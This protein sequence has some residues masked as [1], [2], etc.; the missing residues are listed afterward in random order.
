MTRP[1][2]E[3]ALAALDP[4]RTALLDG[5]R[6]AAASAVAAA[7]ADASAA[8]DAARQEAVA[9]TAAARARG[10]QDAADARAAELGQARRRARATVLAAQAAAWAELRRRSREAVL[11]LRDD[12]GYPQVVAR[13]GDL[14]RAELGG[15]ATVVE[16]PGGGVVAE[17]DGRRADLG[18]DVLADQAL[19]ALGPEVAALWSP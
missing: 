11:R 9:I 16:H 15:S 3:N 18:L 12:P 8:L 19:Q 13:L 14:A 10:E 5:A 7:D 2:A 6:A 1:L 17:A 4:L